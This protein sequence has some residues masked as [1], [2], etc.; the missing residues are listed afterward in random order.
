MT[1]SHT[2]MS[3][4]YFTAW[5]SCDTICAFVRAARPVRP[6]RPLYRAWMVPQASE[7]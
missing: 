7:K 3:G 6:S 2:Y 1:H 4:M 5:R